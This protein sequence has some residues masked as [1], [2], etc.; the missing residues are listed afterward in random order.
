MPFRQPEWRIYEEN[1]ILFSEITPLEAPSAWLDLDALNHNIDLVNQGIGDKKIRIASKSVRSVGVLRHIIE[2]TAN[3]IGIMSYSAAESLF[4]LEQGFDDILCA[5]PQWDTASIARCLQWQ[6]NGKK[7]MWIIDSPT[8]WQYLHHIAQENDHP[9]DVCLDI[10]MSLPL[11][12]LYFGTKRSPLRDWSS[13]QALLQQCA[14][15]N[16][17]QVKGLM[18]Y[19]AQ[20]AGLPEQLP[21]KKYLSAAVHY[22]KKRSKKD[23][24]QRRSHIVHALRE[25]GCDLRLVNGGGSGSL[26]FTAAQEEVSEVTIGS[27]YYFPAYFSY[28][29]SMQKFKPAAGFVLQASRSSEPNIITCHSGGFIA[30]GSVGKDKAPQVLYPANLSILP[31]EGFG[32]VQTPMNTHGSSIQMGDY[33]WCRHAKAGELCEHFN[34]LYA[35]QNNQLSQQFTTY[36]GEGKCFH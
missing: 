22:L 25:T 2:R 12:F 35:Y 36:R 4:L 13:V 14:P 21:G 20:I 28:M 32:E 3:Y 9:I 18:G 17:V 31:N 7:I 19:E 10:N 26:L 29:S 5:Y 24:A 33:V 1:L 27:A 11:P 15:Y 34:T 6:K 30:S 8:H 23:V 16:G